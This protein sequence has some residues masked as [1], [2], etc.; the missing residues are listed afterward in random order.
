MITYQED[1]IL[2]IL[3]ETK[4]IPVF[5]LVSSVSVYLFMRLL[6]RLK[7]HMGFT[8]HFYCFYR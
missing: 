8:L 6:E 3:D 4:F 2:E 1:N 5:K 7:L